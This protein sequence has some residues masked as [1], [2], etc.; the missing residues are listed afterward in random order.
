ML[1][2]G[3]ARHQQNQTSVLVVGD[4]MVDRYI[5]GDASRLSPEAPVPVV[6]ARHH[7]MRPGGAAN[8]ASG[9]AALGFSTTLLAVTGD[10]RQAGELKALVE[11]HGVSF[12]ALRFAKLTTTEKIRVLSGPQ[13]IVR[14]DYEIQIDSNTLDQLME[15]YHR[16]LP[17]FSAVVFSDYAKGVL[18]RLPVM[19]ASARAL[20]IPTFVDPK[21]NDPAHYQNAFLIKPNAKEFEA[22]LG[23]EGDIVERASKGIVQYN[24]DHVVVTQSGEGMVHV[25]AE[26]R[27][28]H[29]PAQALEVFDVSG[30]GDT[31]LAALTAGCLRGYSMADAIHLANRAAAIAVSHA[32]TFVVTQGDIDR[33]EA[34]DFAGGKKIR[35]ADDLM[36]KL[37]Q[38]KFNGARIVFTNGCFDIVHA[39]HIR[40]LEE[41][42]RQGDVLVVGINSDES[43]RRLKG[44]TRPVN[45]F[46]DRAEVIAGLSCV[47]FVVRFEEDTP[48]ALV[49]RIKPHVLVKGGDY[50]A[51]DIVGAE[52]VIANGGRVVVVPLLDGRSTTSILAKARQS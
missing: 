29:Y 39:G 48:Q 32:G 17:S 9:I 49:D 19:L 13:Q 40:V 35:T 34:E 25:N 47:D 11:E 14:I 45:S 16:I 46:E 33:A 43:V 21:V 37:G 6:T 38:T 41:S 5:I 36:R 51:E 52:V 1:T 28:D 12:C 24:W 50:R 26:K 8:V 44:S 30:A 23:S 27:A 22:L 20:G 18:D 15:E 4:V 31:V 42:K 3:A 7:D 10:D 2:T